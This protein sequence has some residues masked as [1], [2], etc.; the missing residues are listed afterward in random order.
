MYTFDSLDVSHVTFDSLDV[1]HVTFDSL[2]VSHVTCFFFF[3][4]LF[5]CQS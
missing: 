1:S 3:V 4:F 5:I 2:D